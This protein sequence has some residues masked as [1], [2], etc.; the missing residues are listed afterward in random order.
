MRIDVDEILLGK[1]LQGFAHRRTRDLEAGGDVLFLD[2]RSGLQFQP[3]DGPAQILIYLVRLC[4]WPIRRRLDLIY[5]LF[6]RFE[7]HWN[8]D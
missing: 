8:A 5:S 2:G 1:P 3:D 6:E 7:G 4:C